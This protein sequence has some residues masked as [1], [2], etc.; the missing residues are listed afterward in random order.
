[1]ANILTH[2]ST[3]LERLMEMLILDLKDVVS[4]RKLKN[5]YFVL[6]AKSL[7]PLLVDDIHYMLEVIILPNTMIDFDKKELTL[8]ENKFAQF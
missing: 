7:Q 5:I 1:M 6:I 4:I 2:F 3:I 8:P